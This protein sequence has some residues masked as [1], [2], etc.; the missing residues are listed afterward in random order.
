MTHTPPPT[1]TSRR[2]RA[3][4][5][6]FRTYGTREFPYSHC[7]R[8]L[9]STKIM[10]KF[11]LLM[12]LL[13]G[14][15]C[16]LPPG[17]DTILSGIFL[18]DLVN[19]INGK[20]ISE[21]DGISYLD[22]TDGL[23]LDGRSLTS[24]LED[25]KLFSGDY[26]SV[27]EF[28]LHPSIRDEEY[29]RHSSLWAKQYLN[30]DRSIQGARGVKTMEPESTLPAY[31]SP[32]NPCPIGYTAAQGCIEDFQNTASYS[33]KYQGAQDCMCDTEH[34]FDCPGS[35]DIDDEESTVYDG[36]RLNR[37]LQESNKGNNPFLT[38]E[39]LPVAAKKG[40]NVNF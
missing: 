4:P 10:V 34:M 6:R 2:Y 5:D 38:G 8:P 35:N 33:R 24:G 21:G 1:P 30:G 25:E 31:C 11:S 15:F 28:N 16:Y 13:G 40:N 3:I 32:P 12:F 9:G 23:P 20:G 37:F 18:R 19:R 17:K 36:Y 26:D 29:L 7:V 27:G 22:F 39:K 14:A